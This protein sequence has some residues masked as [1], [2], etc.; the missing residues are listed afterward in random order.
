[1]DTYKVGRAEAKTL[2]ISLQYG[3]NFENWLQA[4][5]NI[6]TVKSKPTKFIVKFA[7]ELEIIAEQ[8][9]ARNPKLTKIVLKRQDESQQENQLQR[10][11]VEYVFVKNTREEY[12]R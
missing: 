7:E 9:S 6:T 4:K 5:S 2:F 12:W 1:M 10:S 11:I 3:G 8:I